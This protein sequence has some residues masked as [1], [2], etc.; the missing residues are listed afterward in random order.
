[1]RFFWKSLTSLGLDSVKGFWVFT[2][3]GNFYE[4]SQPK[5][6]EYS[7]A[8]IHNLIF[9]AFSKGTWIQSEAFLA[10]LLVVG[11]LFF[12]GVFLSAFT[13]YEDHYWGDSKF[14]EEL[15]FNSSRKQS[16]C[17]KTA[18]TSCFF[19]VNS[20]EHWKL[21]LWTIEKVSAAVSAG[22]NSMN[23]FSLLE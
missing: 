13:Y 9:L 18:P 19:C 17:S 22:F 3:A 20:V 5:E 4:F 16:W 6:M 21:N 8:F 10:G 15:R 11:A 2:A 14:R 1:M 12:A 7:I 23:C